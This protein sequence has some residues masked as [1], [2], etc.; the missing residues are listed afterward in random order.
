MTLGITALIVMTLIV[1]TLAIT[2]LIIMTLIKVIF[3]INK[4]QHSA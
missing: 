3:N 2:T 1:M 4:T